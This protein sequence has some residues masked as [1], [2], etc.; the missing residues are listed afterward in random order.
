MWEPAVGFEIG[1]LFDRAR[2][3][4][5]EFYQQTDDALRVIGVDSLVH[6]LWKAPR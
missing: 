2:T 5:F 6:S 3:G 1:R 4:R